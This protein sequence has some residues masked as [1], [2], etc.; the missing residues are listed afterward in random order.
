MKR[1]F[2]FLLIFIITVPAFIRLINSAYFSMHDD[3][4]IVRLFLLDEGIRQGRLYPRWVEGLGFG[5]GYPLFNFYPPLVYY[6][7]LIFHRSGFS[8][9][10]SIKLVF[11]TGFYVGA[12]GIYFFTT[13]LRGKLAGFLSATMYTYFFY[14]A[15][16]IYVRGAL[17]EFFSMGLFP[18]VFLALLN[19]SQKVKMKN[20]L[21]LGI[22]FALLILTHPLIAFSSLF[23]I[24]FFFLFFVNTHETK[25]RYTLYTA[26][27]FVIGLLF[28]AFFW[29]PSLVERHY[30]LVDDILTKELANYKIHYI[31]LQQFW[32]SLWGY[33]GS[34]AGHYDGMTFQLGKIPIGLTIISIVLF[35]IVAIKKL[36]TGSSSIQIKQIKYYTLFLF[37]LF[38][39]LF[40]T[41]SYSAFI[42]DNIRYL[43][44]LQ[45]PWRFLTFAGFFIAVVSG[46]TLYFFNIIW[47]SAYSRSV[48]RF[49]T[50]FLISAIIIMYQ[51]YFTP[52][53]L[54]WTDDLRLTTQEEITW[55]VSR[56]S[57]EFVPKGIATTQSDIGTTIVAID[58]NQRPQKPYEIISGKVEITM[59]KNNFSEKKF[60]VNAVSPTTL[61]LNTFY[62]PGWHAY[63]DNQQIVINN[64]NKYKLITITIPDGIHQVR[65]VFQD[66]IIRKLANIMSAFA[67]LII[68]AYTSFIL[69]IRNKSR[70]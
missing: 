17:A 6:L 59:L 20:S 38:F 39:S 53:K 54:L 37:L 34:I 70:L 14:H 45:F 65:F 13:K 63:V 62:F 5:F 21:L 33:G 68:I 12:L 31:Y 16:I 61:R 26:Y 49:I 1:L 22:S 66:T 2:P 36:F 11:I 24:G 55:R 57:F 48:Q 58:K 29:L 15:V 30:T 69:F 28:S 27:G 40:M 3:Q 56:S 51:K 25:L 50:L 10:W 67:F 44:Y 9:I 42:W 19:L 47:H 46:Y 7:A 41:T 32:Y 64:L 35:I 18:F 8:L 4:H 43:W 52:Q 60:R 23:Y